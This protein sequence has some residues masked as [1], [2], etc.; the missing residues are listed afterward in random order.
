[1]RLSNGTYNPLYKW[2]YIQRK[3]KNKLSAGRIKKLNEV[4]F[5]WEPKKSKSLKKWA[6]CYYEFVEFIK[7]NP[8]KMP[9]AKYKDESLLYNWCRAQLNNKN[10]LLPEQIE[11][12]QSTGYPWAGYFKTTQL[13]WE[14]RLNIYINFVKD[15][16]GKTIPN[17][18]NG[19]H[20]PLAS[21]C[22]N[23]RKNK[24]KM[25]AE[26]IEKLNAAGFDWKL[27]G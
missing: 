4:G 16:P 13:L 12:L 3:N 23:Q 26:R 25:S 5:D 21:W 15:N 19:K 24:N 9:P 14:D 1:M 7:N 20:N 22:Y 18:L 2:C 8:D 10:K 6:N 11:L 17:K 27:S